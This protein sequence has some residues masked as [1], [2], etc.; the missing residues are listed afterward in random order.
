MLSNLIDALVNRMVGW[1]VIILQKIKHPV[2]L[3]QTYEWMN[4]N[5]ITENH[6]NYVWMSRILEMI[7]IITENKMIFI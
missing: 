1:P 4:Y 2:N 7:F 6:T 5:M 3:I